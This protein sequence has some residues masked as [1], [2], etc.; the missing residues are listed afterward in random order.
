MN[1]TAHSPGSE[2]ASSTKSGIVVGVDGSSNNLSAVGWAARQAS[3]AGVPLRVLTVTDKNL[4]RTP[5]FATSLPEPFDF[6]IYASDI[7]ERVADNLLRDDPNL[8]V[9][10]DVRVADPLTGLIDET[11]ESEFVVVGKRGIGVLKRMLAG[12][13]SIALAGRSRTPVVIV[14]DTW[15][16]EQHDGEPVLVAVDI[17]HDSD[18]QLAFGF[19]RAQE[20]GVPLVAL[21]VWETHPAI[22]HD[23]EDIT[24]WGAEARAAVEERLA[25]W[26]SKYPGVEAL[27]AQEHGH[28]T[29]GLLD[30]AERS[31]L[32]VLGRKSAGTSP[33]GLGFASL[34]R[35]VLHAS[36]GPVAVVPTDNAG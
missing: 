1:T 6:Q 23:P 5:T 22:T 13:M 10:A 2:T 12:S 32:L 27:A 30:A 28:P 34:T 33:V 31:Q 8:R 4:V 19:A 11:K 35:N 18:A 21:H 14:P 26:R 20:L 9:E 16:H 24:R 15:E 17:D 29:E 36:T 3:R 7:V 25:P